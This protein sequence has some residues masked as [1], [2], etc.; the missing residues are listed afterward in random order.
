MTRTDYFESLVKREGGYVDHPSD[1]G[2]PTNWGITEAV[3][4]DYGW[5]GHM[6]DLPRDVALEIYVKRYWIEPKFNEVDKINTTLAAEMLDTGVNMGIQ[7]PG[8]FL[9]RALN[10][11]NLRGTIHPDL[12]DD[13]RVGTRTLAALKRYMDHRGRASTRVLMRLMEAQQAVRYMEIA[14]KNPSQEDFMFG[15]IDHRI[16]NEVY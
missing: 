1:R 9:Q 6:R 11:L 7:W 14:T 8:L 3:A 10:V 16:Q 4:R 2:G 15:W 12:V 5:K 13:G